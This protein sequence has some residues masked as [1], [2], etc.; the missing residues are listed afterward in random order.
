M[1]AANKRQKAKTDERGRRLDAAKRAKRL[2]RIQEAAMPVV[3]ELTG[4][5]K[6]RVVSADLIDPSPRGGL[7]EV[8]GEHYLL[9]LIVRRMLASMYAASLLGLLWSYIQ[10]A[11]R[12]LIYYAVM[13]WVLQMHHGAPSYA[14]HLFTG[15]VFLHFFSESWNGATRSIFQNRQLVLKMRMPREIF[16]V[17]AITVAAYHTAPQLVLLAIICALSGWHITVGG[18]FAALLGF[19]IILSYVGAIALVFSSLNVFYRDFQNIVQTLLQF[20]HFLV[21]MMYPFSKVWAISHSRPLLYD[22]Y[23]LNP[24]AEVVLLMQKFFWWGTVPK[25]AQRP[26]GMLMWQG[27]LTREFPPDLWSRG[28]LMLAI[29]MVLFFYAQRFFSRVED[30]FPE[31]L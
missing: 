31:R 9:R 2:A 11:M 29:G 22:I 19:A 4:P 6:E 28:L 1:R 8:L 7:G 14:V 30:K 10:P 3:A 13:G 25:S 23:M 12:F 21:P 5:K 27:K 18:I 17:A 20:M 24:L 26:G 16:P 15:I